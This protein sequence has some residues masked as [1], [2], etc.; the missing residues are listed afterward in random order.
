MRQCGLARAFYLCKLFL[1]GTRSADQLWLEMRNNESAETD[2]ELK[3]REE[4]PNT[5]RALSGTREEAL[6][7]V[8]C[9]CEGRGCTAAVPSVLS[10]CYLQR[11]T[12]S[13]ASAK[14]G[15]HLLNPLYRSDV[16]AVPPPHSGKGPFVT[17]SNSRWCYNI[18]CNFCRFSAS[19][20]DV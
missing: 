1:A 5:N 16:A 11:Y 17:C 15:S 14:C 3:T 18:P 13:C 2:K 10:Q 7:L 12:L 19:P 6:H 4:G 20:T 8:S 9:E